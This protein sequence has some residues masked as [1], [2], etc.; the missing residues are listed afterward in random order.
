MGTGASDAE[1]AAQ[2]T[3]DLTNPQVRSWT[4][5]LGSQS[6]TLETAA[7]V[8]LVLLLWQFG[9]RYLPAHDNWSKRH[10]RL[11]WPSTTMS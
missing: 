5:W 6:D 8:I 1:T 9:G 3:S 4:R 7:A 10:G 11:A 2:S